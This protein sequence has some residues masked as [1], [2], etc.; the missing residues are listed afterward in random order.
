MVMRDQADLV[1]ATES[2]SGFDGLIS[3][4]CYQW[5]H[6]VIVPPE[7]PLLK[8]KNV[9]LE[10]IAHYP[11][12]TYDS[13]FAGR[14]KIDHAFQLRDLKPDVLL[15]AIDADVIKTYVELGMGIG[16]IAGMAFDAERDKHLRAIPVGH[17]FGMN[18]SRVAIKQGAYLR[19]YIY[20]F[21]ELL[22]PT[23]TRKMVDSVLQGNKDNYDL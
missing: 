7:H 5:E 1:I 2:I 14:S 13:A 15:E 19:S 23:L 10:E 21:I 12:V 22:N 11:L 20:T 16:I 6:V 3:L 8:L 17:L 4:P 18:V 9:T